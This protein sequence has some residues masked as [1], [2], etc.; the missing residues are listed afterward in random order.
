MIKVLFVCYGNICRSV[1]AEMI[2]KSLIKDNG[3]SQD[4]V[5]ASAGTSD[6]EARFNSPIYPMAKQVLRDNYIEVDAHYARQMTK[7]DYDKYDYIICMEEKNVKA[8]M[9]IIREDPDFKVYK[10]M[11]FTDNPIDIDDPWYHRDFERTFREISLGCECLFDN[12]M[13]MQDL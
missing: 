9:D 11:D 4:F 3:V 2:F 1:M 8:V 5:V 13:K 7:A 12:L 6:E 10:L